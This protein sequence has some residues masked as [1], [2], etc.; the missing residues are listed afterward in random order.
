[1]ETL[2]PIAL[3]LGSLLLGAVSPGPS[4]V[5]VARIS[6]G[7]SRREGI[8]ASIGMGIGGIIFATLAL[9]GLQVV[10][11]TI[12]TLYLGLT[13]FGGLYLIYLGIHIWRG[14]NVPLIVGPD[15]AES[16]SPIKKSFLVGLITQICNPKTAIVYGSIFAA[17]LPANF[18]DSAFYV[19]PFLIFLVEAG[20]YS[21]VAIVFSS[22]TPRSAY[23][24]SKPIYDRVA[25]AVMFG[26]GAKLIS[27]ANT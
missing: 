19:L 3:I 11:T 18:P 9:V 4:F 6:M 24:R 13:I 17:L 20:W 25:G 26:L 23:L 14:A 7:N 27:S 10:L 8:A 12:P 16:K 22:E 1:M 5:V 2:L 15:N 21:I